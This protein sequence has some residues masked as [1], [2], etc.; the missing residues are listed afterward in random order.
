[1]EARE[2]RAEVTYREKG[3]LLPENRTEFAFESCSSLDLKI[4]F[5]FMFLNS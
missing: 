4:K 2:R 5:S 1:M 3:G